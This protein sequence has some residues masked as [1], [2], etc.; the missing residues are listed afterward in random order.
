MRSFNGRLRRR[1]GA[2]AVLCGLLALAFAGLAP[3]ALAQGAGGGF[4]TAAPFA[5]LTDG[6]SGAVLFEKAADEPMVPASM[7]KVM[8]LAVLFE[9][10][11]QGRVKLDDEFTISESA[12]RRGG[13]LSRGSTM[14]AQLGSRIKVSDLIQGVTVQSGN[15]AAIAIAEGVAGT[16]SAFAGRM[17]A[18]AR[19]LGLTKSVFV[20]ATG[21]HDPEQKTTARELALLARHVIVTYPELYK[22]FGMREFTWNK[23]RQQNRNPLLAMD[24]GADGLKTGMVAESGFGLVGSTVQNGQ[25]LI[26]V[27]N[28]LKTDKDRAEEAR[29]LINLGYRSFETKE[30]FAAGAVIGEAQ[31][32]GGEPTAVGL[33]AKGPVR[34]LVPR[35]STERVEARIVYRGPLRPPVKAGAE[36]ARLKVQ[37][38]S[39]QALDVPLYADRDAGPAGLGRRAFDAASEFALGFVRRGFKL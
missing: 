9:E 39:V 23:I 13:A 31:V 19:E 12:W 17:T 21:L 2:V 8:T 28:G 36:V 5:I 11:R 35:G 6:D 27:V 38:G 29:K 16:E 14:Y 22:Y 3:R 1:G 30:L 26:V 33:V 7:T 34:I 25:R 15:D 10:I 24:I 37:R 20:N 4:Q 32:Y 18:R